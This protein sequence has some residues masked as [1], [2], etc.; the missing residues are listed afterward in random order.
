VAGAAGGGSEQSLFVILPGATSVRPEPQPANGE[1]TLKGKL[2]LTVS[3]TTDRTLRGRVRVVPEADAPAAWVGVGEP[4][5]DFPPRGTQTFAVDVTVPAG[6]SGRFAYRPYVA[7]AESPDDYSYSGPVFTVE[8]AAAPPARRGLPGWL[9]ALLALIGVLA[10]LLIGYAVFRL[11]RPAA[12]PPPRIVAEGRLTIPSD[13]ASDLDVPGGSVVTGAQPEFA[14]ADLQNVP[15]GF[16]VV[17]NLGPANDAGLAEAP[18]AATP[19]LDEC[20]RATYRRTGI[21]FGN[22]YVGGHLCVRTGRGN[23]SLVR[24]VRLSPTSPQAFVAEIVFTT[25]EAP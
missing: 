17:Q 10:L 19:G 11:M 2:Q 12:P 6:T 18:G 25:W 3:N 22:L 20:R 8:A 9:I 13:S 14:A 5:R 24:I 7:W 1:P 21:P 4:E 15:G 16:P 23:L